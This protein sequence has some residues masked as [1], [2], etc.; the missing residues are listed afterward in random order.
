MPKSRKLG[1]TV[2]CPLCDLIYFHLIGTLKAVLLVE[3][4]LIHTRQPSRA[5]R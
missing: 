2:L 4:D 3:K 5:T 1:C